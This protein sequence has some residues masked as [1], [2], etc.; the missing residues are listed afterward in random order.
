VIGCLFND[1]LVASGLKG[2]SQQNPG[3]ALNVISPCRLIGPD[4]FL[5][6]QKLPDGAQALQKDNAKKD[7]S[8]TY[9]RANKSER[10]K[11]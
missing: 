5:K 1:M 3:C 8:R 11:M 4:A 6:K 2:C 10:G 7:S 9:M